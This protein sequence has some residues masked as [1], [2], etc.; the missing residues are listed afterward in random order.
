[1]GITVRKTDITAISKECDAQ[2]ETKVNEVFHEQAA[3]Y[4]LL[5]YLVTDDGRPRPVRR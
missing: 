3:S 1:M 2:Y 4:R 5:D